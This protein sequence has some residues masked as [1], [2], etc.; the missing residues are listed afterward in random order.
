VLNHSVSTK[1][2]EGLRRSEPSTERKSHLAGPHTGLSYQDRGSYILVGSGVPL[3]VGLLVVFLDR[4]KV[5]GKDFLL[6]NLRVVTSVLVQD[7]ELA[8][9]IIVRSGYFQPS[10][11]FISHVTVV[12]M[13]G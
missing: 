12:E 9:M 7:M 11:C 5:L 4:L 3:L 1:E 13:V 6:V 10:S 2:V 8:R